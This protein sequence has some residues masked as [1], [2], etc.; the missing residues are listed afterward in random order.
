LKGLSQKGGERKI[1]NEPFSI[2][3]IIELLPQL[4]EKQTF[5]LRKMQMNL[6]DIVNEK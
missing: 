2:E 1:S 4:N 5:Y 3:D 6:E